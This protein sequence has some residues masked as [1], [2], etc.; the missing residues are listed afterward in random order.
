MRN[1]SGRG[2][3][4]ALVVI[5]IAAL[6]VAWLAVTQLQGLRGPQEAASAQPTPTVQQARDAVDALNGRMQVSEP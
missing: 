2:T 1:R 6:V 4:L 5:L 3:G